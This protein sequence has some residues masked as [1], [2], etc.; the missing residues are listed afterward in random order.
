MKKNIVIF[1]ASSTISQNII[2]LYK[3]DKANIYAFSR[4]KLKANGIN[5]FQTNYNE[6]SFHK[7]KALFK[8]I[9]IDIV[10]FANGF[11]SNEVEDVDNIFLINSIIPIKLTDMIL[12]LKPQKCK[13]IFFNSPSAERGRQSTFLYGAAKKSID[14]F[15]QGMRHKY[16][17]INKDI[18]FYNIIIHPTLTKMTNHL[19]NKGIFVDPNSV[20]KKIIKVLSTKKYH[21]YLS[22]KWLLIM[23]IIKKLPSF[24]F[25]KLNI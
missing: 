1:G 25:N 6:K 15:C 18:E 5:S 21:S 7:I 17:Q 16:S 9:K 23:F 22:F 12:S 3:K 24:I 13:F 2:D 10:F 19:S 8:D 20:A 11:L 4:S 14:I